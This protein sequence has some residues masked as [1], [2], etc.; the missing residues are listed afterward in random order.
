KDAQGYD[1]REYE[2]AVRDSRAEKEIAEPIHISCVRFAAGFSGGTPPNANPNA[3]I[4]F[5][6]NKTT[7]ACDKIKHIVGCSKAIRPRRAGKSPA[8][9]QF[10]LQSR[11]LWGK[12]R[13]MKFP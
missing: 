6:I 13:Y 10:G 3:Q 12:S 2:Y 1:E 8:S 7:R 4:K 5:S 11:R 9:A